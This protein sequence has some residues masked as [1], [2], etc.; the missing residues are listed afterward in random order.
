VRLP[1]AGDKVEFEVH[2]VKGGWHDWRYVIFYKDEKVGWGKKPGPPDHTIGWSKHQAEHQA[3]EHCKLFK[4][5]MN[6]NVL[7]VRV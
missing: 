1:F 7:R 5:N 6:R 4:E 3:I 2:I